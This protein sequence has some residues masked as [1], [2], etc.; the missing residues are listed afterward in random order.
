[1]AQRLTL[2][3][4]ERALLREAFGE[5]EL[6][7][8]R[9]SGG[10]HGRCY[11]VRAEDIDCAVRMPAA[12]E[13]EYRLDSGAEQRILARLAA[14]GLSPAVVPLEP[15]LGLVATRYLADARAWSVGDARRTENVVRL[16]ARL[17]NLHALELDVPSYA[18]AAAARSYV[19]RAA[20]RGQLTRE[21]RAWRDELERRAADFETR[22]KGTTPC[23]NDLVASN[24]LDDG[25]LRL[26]DLEYA[27]ASSPL[28][29][30]AGFAGLNDLDREERK[31][32]VTAYYGEV[33]SPIGPDELDAAI[34]LVRLLAM[35][36]ALAASGSEEPGS[37][38]AAFAD[39]MA[40]MLM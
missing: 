33:R 14:S 20:E 30:L 25:S 15:A 5:R 28:L 24:V 9:L 3:A 22:H 29:D 38:L 34:R 16:A 32:L 1:M 17:R 4:R 21:Q 2:P 11:R 26:V 23:H 7:I 10:V 37:P 27:A 18:C 12:D 6:V 19:A 40:A 35:F 13:G 36:W 39:A 31:L 8:D